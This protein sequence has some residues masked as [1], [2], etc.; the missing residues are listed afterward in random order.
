MILK[1]KK[2]P[3]PILSKKAKPIIK[4]TKDI[5]K[6]AKNMFD[7][8]YSTNGAGLAANQVGVLKRLVVIN[9]AKENDKRYPIAIINPEITYKNGEILEPEGCLSFPEGLRAE[10]KRFA[11]VTMN[12]LNL[13]GKK[14]SFTWEGTLSRIIQHEIDHI[15]GVLFIDHLSYFDKIKLS[16]LFSV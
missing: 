9:I 13:N 5:K 4:I 6:L 12:G 2:Y 3:D 7:T 16:K 11:K 15:N 14:I 8:M 1:I 10:V